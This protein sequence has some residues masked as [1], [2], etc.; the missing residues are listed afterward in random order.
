MIELTKISTEFFNSPESLE[1]QT[2]LTFIDWMN[3]KYM[4]KIKN[5]QTYNEIDNDI[6]CFCNML[7]N[8]ERVDYEFSQELYQFFKL[9][10]EYK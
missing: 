7:Y 9:K 6:K 10:L 4:G 8:R 5:E 1:N 2:M 3:K